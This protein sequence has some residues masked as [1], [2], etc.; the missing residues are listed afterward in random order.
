MSSSLIQLI[1]LAGI[2]IF[3]VLKL[4]SVLGTREGFEK[5]PVDK[6]AQ[7]AARSRANLEVIE[8]GPDHDIVDHVEEN[9]SSAKALADMKRVDPSFGVGDFLQGARG[10]YEMIFMAFEKGDLDSIV[11]FLSEDVFESFTEVVDDRVAKGL[12][13]DAHFVGIR[14]LTLSDASFDT[15]NKLAEITVKFV[16]EISS[17]VKNADGEIVEGDASA[18]KRQKDV[19]TFGR[20]M[21]SADPNW[22]L[23]ATG[24]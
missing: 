24:G 18:I 3:L 20:D 14:E 16:A 21:S 5:P 9:S 11:P 19:W 7:P 4:R 22:Q 15:D 23:V 13:I 2:A 6:A 8:G 10:A 12:S 1:V 17:V